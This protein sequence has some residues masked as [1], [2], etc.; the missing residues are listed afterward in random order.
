MVT[1]FKGKHMEDLDLDALRKLTGYLI[2]NGVHG[3]ILHGTSGE[4]LMQNH[5]E[6]NRVV[7]TT[8]EAARG[9]VPVIAG[10]SEAST[11]NVVA[12]GRAAKD[13]GADAVLA[14]G[15]IYF[16]TSDRGLDLHFQGILDGVDLPLMIYNI[17]SWTGYNISK[18]TIRKLIDDNSGRVAGV[19][20]TTDNLEQF[21]EYNRA[22]GRQTSLMIG[23][24]AL[25]FSA[26]MLGAAGGVLGSANILPKETSSIYELV[27]Y[28]KVS[29]SREMQEKIAPFAEAMGLG[30]FPAPLKEG[31]KF[32]G[33][34]CGDPRPPLEPLSRQEAS[35]V[36]ESLEWKKNEH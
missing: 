15:P 36:H 13:V 33:L 1:P 25:I 26:M 31:L 5:E 24:D 4:F 29:E 27:R 2:E 30:T 34:D 35:K 14:T 9:K 11:K 3:L 20:F 18:D 21:Y 28:G 8:V 7:Q 22:L 12:L 19:K 16:K 6:R 23:S 10:I 17:P 32:I